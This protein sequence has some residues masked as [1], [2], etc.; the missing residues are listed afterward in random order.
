[1]EPFQF[2]RWVTVPVACAAMSKSRF[3]A[4]VGRLAVAVVAVAVLASACSSNSSPSST[5]ATSPTKSS[6]ESSSSSTTT[7]A[8]ATGGS[9]PAVSGI[10][11][12][13]AGQVSPAGTFGKRPTVT[14]PTGSPPTS[15]EASDLIVGTGAVA[16]AGQNVTVQYDG[17]SWTTGK[18]F[19]ASWNRGQPF[20]FALGQGQVIQGW[21]QGVAG[22]KVGGRREL[23][24]PP[25]LA[26][27]AQ[28]PT[29]AIAT[30]DT[31]IFVVDLISVG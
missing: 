11:S 8:H 27:G 21:D 5:A 29:P 6:I 20:S 19:D 23:I 12:I 18:E 16:K 15:L 28:P 31:L 14:V 9:Q 25:S 4:R 22:M 2:L 1:M 3:E 26:Y 17:Y 10:A 13:P 30:N 24:I 7:P